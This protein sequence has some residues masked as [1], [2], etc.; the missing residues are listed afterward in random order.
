MER[1]ASRAGRE[2]IP[3]VPEDVQGR[4]T[5]IRADAYRAALAAVTPER[6]RLATELDQ[7]RD[8]VVARR[9][10]RKWKPNATSTSDCW[11]APSRNGMLQS[12]NATRRPPVRASRRAR[13]RLSKRNEIGSP[14]SSTR[15]SLAALRLKATFQPNRE[16]S[17]HSPGGQPA[18]TRVSARNSLTT[19]RAGQITI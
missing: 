8:E 6:D 4:L 16:Q 3:A 2:I 13:H 11:R 1:G 9:P 14:S 15:L 5:A 10:S 12:L 18:T 19:Q 7:L 17:M